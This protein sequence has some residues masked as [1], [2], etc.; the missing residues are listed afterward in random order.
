MNL[1]FYLRQLYRAFV[2]LLWIS[3]FNTAYAQ[4][5]NAQIF[6]PDTDNTVFRDEIIH[7]VRSVAR[8]QLP[9]NTL[10]AMDYLDSKWANH[11]QTTNWDI[12]V[13]VYYKGMLVGFAHTRGR[14]LSGVLQ[15]TTSL[16]LKTIP[17]QYRSAA[18]LDN[19]R[20]S[21]AFDYLPTQQY[22]IIEYGKKGLELLGNRVPTRHLTLASVDKQLIN[23]QNYLLRMLD[24]KRYGYFKFY[25]AG[26]DKPET[27]LRTVYSA[28]ALY[29]LLQMNAWQS[30]PVLE[31]L[32]K[33]IAHFILS[34]QVKSG[35]QKGGFYYAVD[36][37]T[38]QKTCR[39]VVGTAA[40]AIFALLAMNQ[41]YPQ[42]VVYLE[43][44]KQAGN[45]LIKQ[46]DMRG[47]VT[48]A[49][50]CHDNQW[51]Y[52]H[53]QSLLYSGQVLS[54]LS[55]L[56]GVTKDPRYLQSAKY[57]VTY[58]IRMVAL[59]GPI[60]GDD[61]RPANSISSSWIL[62]GLLDYVKVDRQVSAIASIQSIA[63]ML[64]SRQITSK[65]DVYNHGRYLD[66]MTASGNGWIN[67]VMGNF[68]HFCKNNPSTK[69]CRPYYQ[70]MIASSRWLLQNTYAP[71]NTFLVKNPARAYGGMITNFSSQTVR[72]DAVCH[73]VNSLLLLE[74]AIPR[75]VSLKE[76]LIHFPER[77]LIEILPLM[78]AGSL[79]ANR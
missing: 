17:K 21:V 45:W 2:L 60:L 26:S 55:R 31:S 32:F 11:Y 77:K 12:T 39:V 48:T 23:N 53:K 4:S 22:T 7:F 59:K 62:M 42:D 72:T 6:V 40:K 68:Y 14:S 3:F 57:I 64:L 15:K 10:V 8:H 61:Y 47:Q 25:D 71:E 66:A 51:Q 36:S 75:S 67:E 9:Q 50:Q 1:M 74:K 33:P 43:H 18:K 28:S 30:Q 49:A 73:G 24:R 78:R 29:T 46:V 56:Y 54:A 27:L 79:P 16:A 52:S 19:Y 13:S 35:P 20:F 38:K 63:S 37:H 44:A 65:C 41:R 58:F 76:E 34:N 70:A 5:S 69:Q